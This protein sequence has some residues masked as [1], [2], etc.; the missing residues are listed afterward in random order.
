MSKERVL[1]GVGGVRTVGDRFR[2]QPRKLGQKSRP[3]SCRTEWTRPTSPE[4]AAVGHSEPGHGRRDRRSSSPP[5]RRCSGVLRVGYPPS[6]RVPTTDV[7][8]NEGQCDPR[9]RRRRV[10]EY[11]SPTSQTVSDYSSRTRDSSVSVLSTSTR[12]EGTPY[13][14]DSLKDPSAPSVKPLQRPPGSPTKD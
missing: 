6:A 13:I 2:V 4:G 3:P 14:L 7:R 12:P 8:P 1:R 10:D 11:S 5:R 9:S